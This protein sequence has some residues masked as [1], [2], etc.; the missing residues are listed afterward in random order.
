MAVDAEQGLCTVGFKCGTLL[1]VTYDSLYIIV[2]QWLTTLVS[3]AGR[4]QH[5]WRV[6]YVFTLV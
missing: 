1:F 6:I 3:Y 2:M 5:H 4:A